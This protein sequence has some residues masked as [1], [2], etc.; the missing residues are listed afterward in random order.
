MFELLLGFSSV[1]SRLLS[2]SSLTMTT[3]SP[4][5]SCACWQVNNHLIWSR[6]VSCC[7]C[8]LAAP[9]PGDLIAVKWPRSDAEQ[10]SDSF[11]PARWRGGPSC[12]AEVDAQLPGLKQRP[13]RPCEGGSDHERKGCLSSSYTVKVAFSI[14]KKGQCS[15]YSVRTTLCRTS[16]LL[17]I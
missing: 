9:L 4:Q 1:S 12:G 16:R 5:T 10:S 15:H 13:G 8:H 2:A 6:P 14:F 17:R 3:W 7:G 11:V